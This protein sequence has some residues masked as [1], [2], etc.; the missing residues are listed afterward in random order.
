[1]HH[2][3]NL[4]RMREAD[5]ERLEELYQPP[6]ESAKLK[7]TPAPQARL[8]FASTSPAVDLP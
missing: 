1:M 5:Y 6:V 7:A 8:G 2:S 4:H 3:V